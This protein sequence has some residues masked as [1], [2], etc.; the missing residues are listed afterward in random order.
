MPAA[1]TLH[2]MTSITHPTVPPSVPSMNG[3][4]VPAI[5]TKIAE[6]SSARRI[7][8]IRSGCIA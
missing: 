5:S 1:A 4:Y 2:S 3:V 6:W 7:W 8:R